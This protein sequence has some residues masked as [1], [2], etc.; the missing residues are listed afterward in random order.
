MASLDERVDNL[1]RLLNIVITNIGVTRELFTDGF[2]K[3]DENFT[4]INQK[5][6][7][8]GTEINA[9]HSKI[10]GLSGDTATNFD[11]VKLEL[12]SIQ[13]GIAKIDTVT[14]YDH[15]VANMK[16]VTGGQKGQ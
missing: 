12:A 8:I 16:I 9:L 5:V 6:S 4:N 13:E 7:K 14:Q 2:K 15:I 11:D 1:E 10:D 3:I